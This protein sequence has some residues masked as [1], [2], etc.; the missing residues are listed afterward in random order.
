MYVLYS[1]KT[2]L[3]DQS[4][5]RQGPIYVIIH[6]NSYL[7]IRLWYSL[8]DHSE[9]HFI[10]DCSLYKYDYDYHFILILIIDIIIIIII[11]IS[12]H[13]VTKIYFLVWI[14]VTCLLVTIPDLIFSAILSQPRPTNNKNRF[15]IYSIP[16]DS[17][18]L[19]A[20]FKLNLDFE[21]KVTY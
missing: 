13:F 12:E 14:C 16:F 21:P 8:Q 5:C 10:W 9:N 7:L 18:F 11:M 20:E 4:E 3:F 1:N 2:W 6:V 15:M 19:A 17:L